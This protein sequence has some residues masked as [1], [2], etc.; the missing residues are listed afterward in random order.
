MLSTGWAPERPDRVVRRDEIHEN[1]WGTP[2]VHRDRSVDVFVRK[3]RRK[4]EAISPEWIYIHTNSSC[5]P[6]HAARKVSRP[7]RAE[8]VDANTDGVH[9]GSPMTGAS[10]V[11][12]A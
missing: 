8:A 7:M 2:W 6:P 11:R 3:V 10:G 1:V 5:E 4:L 9:A 12:I